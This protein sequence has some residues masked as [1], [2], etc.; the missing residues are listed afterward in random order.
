M[1][2]QRT[3]SGI[4]PISFDPVVKLQRT[5]LTMRNKDGTVIKLNAFVQEKAQKS[6]DDIIKEVLNDLEANNADNNAIMNMSTDS[7][8][9]E[10]STS[11]EIHTNVN[12]VIYENHVEE[13]EYETT[14]NDGSLPRIEDVFSKFNTYQ[15]YDKPILLQVTAQSRVCKYI[16]TSNSCSI[17]IFF[18]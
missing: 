5:D 11:L 7:V 3:V 8:Y 13:T 14:Y 9:N 18:Y 10:A 2:R 6:T 17:N 4:Y 12:Y 16:D 15:L 1:K